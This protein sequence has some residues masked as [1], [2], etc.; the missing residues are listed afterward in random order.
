[1]SAFDAKTGRRLPFFPDVEVGREYIVAIHGR[2]DSMSCYDV[3]V[4]SVRPT[5]HGWTG[6]SIYK[7]KATRFS[8]E[9]GSFFVK[10]NATLKRKLPFIFPL[11]PAVLRTPHL[12]YHNT[13]ELFLLPEGEDMTS[14]VYSSKPLE[15]S[16]ETQNTH[17][18]RFYCGLRK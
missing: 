5:E 6:Y 1:M 17:L 3:K 8:R 10:L 14:R 18:V 15:K 16:V 2:I 11:W 12:I 4:E 9:S 13:D 7:V